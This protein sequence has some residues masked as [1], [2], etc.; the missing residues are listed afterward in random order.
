M[1][2]CVCRGEVVVRGFLGGRHTDSNT[3]LALS[4]AYSSLVAHTLIQNWS[5][6][7]SCPRSKET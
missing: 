7:V 1:R 4:V 3:A 6:V 2:E 5:F